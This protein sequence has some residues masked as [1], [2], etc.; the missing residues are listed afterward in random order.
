[1]KSHLIYDLADQDEK[2]LYDMAVQSPRLNAALSEFRELLRKKRKYEDNEEAAKIE[3][4]FYK[5]MEN[6]SVTLE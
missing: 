4:E 6:W 2:S 1:M 3:E 5:I